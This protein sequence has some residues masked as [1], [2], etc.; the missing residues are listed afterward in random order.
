MVIVCK[1]KDSDKHTN[2][3]QEQITILTNIWGFFSGYKNC[4]DKPKQSGFNLIFI[5]NCDL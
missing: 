1:R 4:Q 5:I 2:N 3:R